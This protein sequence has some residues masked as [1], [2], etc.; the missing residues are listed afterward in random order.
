M[1]PTGVP[2]LRRSVVLKLAVEPMAYQLSI[3]RGVSQGGAEEIEL[4]AVVEV[5][6]LAGPFSGE[7]PFDAFVGE[8]R[9]AGGKDGGAEDDLGADGCHH[10][11]G[12]D[13]DSILGDGHDGERRAN[14][15]WTTPGG[16]TAPA[17][18]RLVEEAAGRRRRDRRVAL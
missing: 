6:E 12:R 16:A 17:G 7:H 14:T 5:D 4:A 9:A 13:D 11:F 10:A 18:R 3:L 8:E 15:W 1:S 2:G